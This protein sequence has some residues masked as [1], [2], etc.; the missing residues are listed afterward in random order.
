MVCPYTHPQ[1]TQNFPIYE[2]PKMWY[3][4]GKAYFL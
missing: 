3:N 1:H 4:V 2:R